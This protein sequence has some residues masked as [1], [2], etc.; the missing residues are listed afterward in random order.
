MD[1]ELVIIEGAEA[2]RTFAV[3]AGESKTLG[4][5]PD[6]EIYLQEPGVSR[7]HCTIDNTGLAIT[8]TDLE[9]VNGT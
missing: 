1:I 7:R 4:R 2:G 8:V 6:C 9:S 5:G 3:R